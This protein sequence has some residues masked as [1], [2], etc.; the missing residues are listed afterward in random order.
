MQMND[1]QDQYHIEIIDPQP[2]GGQRVGISYTDVKVT[3][4]PTGIIAQCGYE[5]FVH[6][7]KQIC[8]NMIEWAL[9]EM[10]LK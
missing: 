9:L 2:H 4:L 1:G 10:K 5:R 3:H 7:N 8:M 6:K